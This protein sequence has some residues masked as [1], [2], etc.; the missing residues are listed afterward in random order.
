M[1][2]DKSGCNHLNEINPGGIFIDGNSN[3]NGLPTN[4][5]QAKNSI[6]G[7]V[8]PT[9]LPA[10]VSSLNRTDFL[11]IPL[12]PAASGTCEGNVE[13][14][15]TVDDAYATANL[16]HLEGVLT[17]G[18][19]NVTGVCFTRRDAFLRVYTSGAEETLELL[20]DGQGPN[21]Q[22][23]YSADTRKALRQDA[24]QVRLAAQV[25]RQGGKPGRI[26]FGNSPY[27]Q[28]PVSGWNAGIY[29]NPP[30]R[31]DTSKNGSRGSGWS[32]QH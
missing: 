32:V 1:R 28:N 26:C 17:W 21:A 23:C 12:A 3:P 8:L 13:L 18:K 9:P 5:D 22:T 2:F 11:Y 20:L 7:P 10:S 19:L 16:K 27:P 24:T 30:M 14:G 6:T 29:P 31:L 15:R 4:T 25:Q